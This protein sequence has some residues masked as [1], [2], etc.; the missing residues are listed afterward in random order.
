MNEDDSVQAVLFR[1]RK[2]IGSGYQAL[3]NY[4]NNCLRMYGRP[5]LPTRGKIPTIIGKRNGV[6]IGSDQDYYQQQR[7]VMFHR[8]TRPYQ[9]N[10]LRDI[11][12]TVYNGNVN[13]LASSGGAPLAFALDDDSELQERLYSEGIRGSLS[14]PLSARFAMNAHHNREPPIIG[15]QTD[16]M[17]RELEGHQ[18]DEETMARK[19]QSGHLGNQSVSLISGAQLDPEIEAFK[20]QMLSL[21][22]I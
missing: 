13:M 10:E 12:P 14:N 16:I 15:G 7:N 9:S 4:K 2:G 19:L 5:Y 8:T 20:N 3:K 18:D 17:R 21:I 6:P 11:L 22:H 1:M